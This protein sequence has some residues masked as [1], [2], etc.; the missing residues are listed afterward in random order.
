[1][2]SMEG[3]VQTG[4]SIEQPPIAAPQPVAAEAAPVVPAAPAPP[5]EE[6]HA[7][8]TLYIQ[9]LNEKVKPEGVFL[10][11]GLDGL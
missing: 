8:E 10:S 1:M 4:A 9:N 5:R 7:C 3:V 2:A 6:E 11:F